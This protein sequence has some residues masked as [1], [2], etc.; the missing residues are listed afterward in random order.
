MSHFARNDTMPSGSFDPKVAVSLDSVSR[1]LGSKTTSV[2]EIVKRPGLVCGSSPT[3]YEWNTT[4]ARG[5]V[6]FAVP[7]TPSATDGNEWGIP[8]SSLLYAPI[9]WIS[10]CCT[11][12]TGSLRYRVRVAAT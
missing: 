5:S 7:V 9:G 11:A 2:A 3:A 1:G 12:W 8:A 6:I 4:D 10:Q